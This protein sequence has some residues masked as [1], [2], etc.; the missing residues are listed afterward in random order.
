[1]YEITYEQKQQ[2]HENCVHSGIKVLNSVRDT[3]SL[4]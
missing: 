2:V 4:E 3:P 1:M